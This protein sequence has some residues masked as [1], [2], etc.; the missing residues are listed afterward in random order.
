MSVNASR[1]WEMTV[2]IVK[3][4]SNDISH[5]PTVRVLDL[6]HYVSSDACELPR[7]QNNRIAAQVRWMC[8]VPITVI[9]NCPR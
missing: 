5:C 3:I 4:Q 1:R 9:L 7:T 2:K 8:I 6:R